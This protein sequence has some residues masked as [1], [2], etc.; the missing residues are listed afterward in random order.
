ML[1]RYHHTFGYLFRALDA[2]VVLVAW[3]VSYWVRF[4]FGP[5]AVTK[6]FPAFSAYASLMPLVAMLW[7]GVF[8]LMRVYGSRRMLG[9]IHEVA[10]ILK[11]H[12]LALVLFVALTFLFKEYKYSRLVMIYFAVLGGV[13]LVVCRLALRGALRAMR[14]RGFNLRH[15]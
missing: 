2:C 7:A 11:A 4:F 3:L 8:T 14:A 10:L 13:A 6:G 9:R 5:I 15:V 1:K 12:G